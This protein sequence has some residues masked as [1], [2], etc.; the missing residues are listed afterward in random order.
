MRPTFRKSE[1]DATAHRHIRTMGGSCS[2]P[3]A[4]ERKKSLLSMLR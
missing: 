3:D 2:E 1:V 4:S